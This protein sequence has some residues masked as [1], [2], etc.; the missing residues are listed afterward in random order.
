MP[1]Q[2]TTPKWQQAGD[3]WHLVL[4]RETVAYVNPEF[5]PSAWSFGQQAYVV[6]L[7][8]DYWSQAAVE[9]WQDGELFP[10]E[11]AQDFLLD[12]W[13]SEGRPQ[14]LKGTVRP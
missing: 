2:I 13:T 12:F 1:A 9:Q 6:W 7:N 3:F 4:D 5:P 14:L 10:L 11:H 8:P